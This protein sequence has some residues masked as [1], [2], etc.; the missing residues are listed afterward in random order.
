M[1]TIIDKLVNFKHLACGRLKYNELGLNCEIVSWMLIF[2][3]AKLA[4]A[5]TN[6]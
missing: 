1:M 6:L 2:A 5:I 4:T 3:L